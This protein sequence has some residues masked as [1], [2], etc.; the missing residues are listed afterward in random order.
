MPGER[1]VD[2]VVGRS[3]WQLEAIERAGHVVVSG[4]SVPV[5]TA[6]DLILLKL[7]AGGAQDLWDI[8]QLLAGPE[9]AAL[10]AGVA[11]H[12]AQLPADAQQTWA[13]IVE[14]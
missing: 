8:E 10:E 13:R 6:A 2:V 4:V 1:D 5:V 14:R 9:G 11:S 3:V 7:Y 12:L